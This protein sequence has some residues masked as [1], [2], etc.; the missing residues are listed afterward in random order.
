M[1]GSY[2]PSLLG[3]AP[4]IHDLHDLN[5]LNDGTSVRRLSPRPGP[6]G[7]DTASTP[8]SQANNGNSNGSSNGN[9]IISSI[10]RQT[11]HRKAAQAALPVLRPGTRG[12]E[13]QKLQRLINAR[14]AL[15]GNLASDGVFGLATQQAVSQYQQGVSLVP[16]GVVGK[17]TWYHLLK[18]DRVLSTSGGAR[19]IPQSPAEAMVKKRV[20]EWPLAD[21]FTEVLRRTL[22]KLPGSMRHEFAALLSPTSLAIMVGTLVAWAASHAFGVGEVVDLLLLAGGI[23]FLGMTIFD[24]ADELG[25]F[26]VVT[27]TAEDENDLD[28]A[29][30]H[31]ARVIAI[32]GVAAFVALLTKALRGRGG[33][34][35][36]EEPT[37][38]PTK[39]EPAPETA[40]PKTEAEAAPKRRTARRV[41]PGHTEPTGTPGGKPTGRRTKI[42]DQDDTATKR[43][44]QR[45][46][47]SADA[48][49]N[50]GYKVEQNPKVPGDKNPDYMIEGKTFD[51]KAPA[52]ENT[53]P[54]N[55]A[56][57]MKKAVDRVQSDRIVLNMEDSPIKLDAMKKQLDDWPIEG[58]KEVIVIKDGQV[59]PFWP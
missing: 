53:N 17:E 57:E 19:V 8:Q 6:I 52:P 32:I 13:V 25:D 10:S 50:A 11:L 29:A 12:P 27:S 15:K 38:K 7:L 4:E 20:W 14:M 22:Y 31:L 49:A 18:G 56:S 51:C 43:S 37:R 47:D 59:I 48:L 35:K 1:A 30:T 55:V 54:R 26:L 5:Y 36:L 3:R 41:P 2:Q 24:V 39:G 44:I 58:L 34:G 40:R 33:K 23:F 16:D 21:K 28:E 45:E 9:K 46:N 42:R